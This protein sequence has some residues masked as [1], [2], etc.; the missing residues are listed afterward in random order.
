MRGRLWYRW[1]WVSRGWGGVV[2]GKVCGRHGVNFLLGNRPMHALWLHEPCSE[3][4]KA[5]SVQ[6]GLGFH[7]YLSKNVKIEPQKE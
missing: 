3:L 2:L 7:I 6:N 1:C 4:R 5:G